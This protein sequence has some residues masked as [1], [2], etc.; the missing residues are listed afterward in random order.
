MHDTVLAIQRLYPRIYHSCHVGHV[1]RRSTP[2]RLSPR[3]SAILAHLGPGGPVTARE[4]GAHLGIGA[5]TMSAAI[6]Q[7]ERLGYVRRAARAPR[8]PSRPIVL[9][10]LGK[11]AMQGTSVLDTGRLSALVRRLSPRERRRVVDGLAL[12]AGAALRPEE[13]TP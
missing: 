3:D 6:T 13:A 9:T 5:P 1:R 4:L 7:L 11:D 8:S 10:A 12:L 2:F